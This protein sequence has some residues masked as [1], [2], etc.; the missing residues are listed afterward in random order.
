MDHIDRE[1]L[2]ILQHNAR[3]SLENDRGEDIPFF[4]GGFSKN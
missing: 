3:A 1:I 4:P 2:Q